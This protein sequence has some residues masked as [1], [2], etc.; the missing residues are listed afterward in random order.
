[1]LLQY[2]IN[3]LKEQSLANDA[4]FVTEQDAIDYLDQSPR[5]TR[6]GDGWTSTE[7]QGELHAPH[8]TVK[9]FKDGTWGILG[10]ATRESQ[11]A[12]KEAYTHEFRA[13]WGFFE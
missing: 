11:L 8:F 10:T 1:M 6:T 7:Y 4:M 3:S 2:S 5:T 9:K 13:W 12:D